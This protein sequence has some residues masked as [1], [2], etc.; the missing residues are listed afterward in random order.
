MAKKTT[1]AGAAQGDPL[2]GMSL[3]DYVVEA[4]VA[5]GGM[6]FVYRARHAVLQRKVALKVLRP[7]YAVAGGVRAVGWDLTGWP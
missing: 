1:G 6:G 2:P 4:R 7:E 3:G 5:A